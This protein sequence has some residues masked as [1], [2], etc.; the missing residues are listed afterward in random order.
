AAGGCNLEA[1]SATI[2][3][4]IVPRPALAAGT[5]VI[6]VIGT[7]EGSFGSFF[8]TAV[9][10]HNPSAQRLTGRLIFHSQATEGSSGD[11]SLAYSLGA[12][13]TTSYGDVLAA[14][15]LTR[16]IGSLDIVPDAGSSVPLSAVRVFNDAGAAGT[17]GMTFDQLGLAD[18]IQAG[19]RGI[20]IAPMK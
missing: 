14:M 11:P 1:L 15:G 18:A 3:V 13:E 8:R 9:Q 2:S 17:T 19:Q 4:H 5:R 7:T 10:L 12:G 6:P 16:A 20:V